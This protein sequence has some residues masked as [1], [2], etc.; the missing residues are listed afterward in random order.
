MVI[1]VDEA[2][3]RHVRVAVARL[4]YLYPSLTFAVEGQSIA[5]DGLAAGAED[6]LRR[7]VAYQLYREKIYQDGL[8]MRQAMYEAILK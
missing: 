3:A 1:D 5:I 2:F 6:N 4:Q 7:D 8:P